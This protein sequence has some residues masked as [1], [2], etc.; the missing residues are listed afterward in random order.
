MR[1]RTLLCLRQRTPSHA[2]ERAHRACT[3][4]SSVLVMF[5][6]IQDVC[7]C[8]CAWGPRVGG[9]L[10]RDDYVKKGRPSVARR[11]HDA[12]EDAFLVA[13]KD[14]ESRQRACSPLLEKISFWGIYR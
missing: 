6:P 1:Q 7:V 10:E 5:D 9:I 4:N 14:A 13:P 8:E 11:A 2:K 3:I 12:P